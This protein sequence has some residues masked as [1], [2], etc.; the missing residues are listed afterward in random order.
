MRTSSHLQA[1]A[2]AIAA[3]GHADARG[4]QQFQAAVSGL[5]LT[6]SRALREAEEVSAALEAALKAEREAG[7]VDEY[8]AGERKRPCMVVQGAAWHMLLVQRN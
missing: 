6:R 5:K 4:W 2:A 3:K 8:D 7:R 1:L